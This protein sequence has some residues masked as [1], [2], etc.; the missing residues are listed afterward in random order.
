MRVTGGRLPW[1]EAIELAAR[2]LITRD[3]DDDTGALPQLDAA[4]AVSLSVALAGFFAA[5]TPPERGTVDVYIDWLETLIGQDIADPDEE[6][7]AETL[8]DAL[9]YTLEMPAQIRAEAD[10][11]LIARDLAAMQQFKRTLR[12]LLSAQALAGSLGYG[13]RDRLRKPSCAI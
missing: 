7:I 2:P 5:V 13:R 8:F 4:L 3:G 12:G 11:A 6:S 1:L 10:E 9:D